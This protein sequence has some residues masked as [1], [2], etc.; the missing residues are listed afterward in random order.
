M[1]DAAQSQFT[2]AAFDGTTHYAAEGPWLAARVAAAFPWLRVVISMR[3]PISQALAMHLHNLSHGRPDLCMD[4]HGG[5]IAP[6]IADDLQQGGRARYGPGV[7]AW[8]AAF[9]PDQVHLVQY[10]RA[11][12][13]AT[14]AP[15]LAAMKAFLGVDAG[16]P[17][18]TLPLSERARRA[19]AAG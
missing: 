13:P 3:D 6:C 18:T 11:I 19:A 5:A 15:D 12:A 1:R 16:L 17:S 9:P 10:E 14:M 7:A 4:A 2:R 8:L